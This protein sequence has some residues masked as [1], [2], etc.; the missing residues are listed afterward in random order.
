MS[1]QAS[2][3]KALLDKE[4]YPSVYLFKFIVKNDLSKVVDIKRCFDETAEFETHPSRNGNYISVS[5]KQMMLNSDDI[6]V[7]YERVSK[8]KNVIVL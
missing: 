4:N 1:D 7:R 6:L 5:I 3:L 8:I 2:R